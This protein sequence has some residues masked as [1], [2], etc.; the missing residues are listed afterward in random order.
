MFE[1]IK[2]LGKVRI[3]EKSGLYWGEVLHLCAVEHFQATTVE[4]LRQAIAGSVAGNEFR[5][6]NQ[7]TGDEAHRITL[8][9]DPHLY[10]H[11]HERA[12]SAG[13]SV[14]EWIIGALE[15]VIDRSLFLEHV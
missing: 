9:L 5:L 12:E 15:K 10:D 4:E 1:P 2:L 13:V 7:L 6:A 8:N 11:I 3:D 14:E